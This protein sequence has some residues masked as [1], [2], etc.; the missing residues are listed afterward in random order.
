MS[1]IP[2][3]GQETLPGV[4]AEVIIGQS[5][6]QGAVAVIAISLALWRACEPVLARKRDQLDLFRIIEDRRR[7]RAVQAPC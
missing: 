6:F 2:I 5:T 4:R 7:E 3:R 1:A